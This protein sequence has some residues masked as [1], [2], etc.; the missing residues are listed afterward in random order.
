MTFKERSPD[1]LK[2]KIVCK[3]PF[4]NFS[5]LCVILQDSLAFL[6]VSLS[7]APV[8]TCPCVPPVTPGLWSDGQLHAQRLA[9]VVAGVVDGGVHNII[10]VVHQ[11]GHVLQGQAEHSSGVQAGAQRKTNT[12]GH[13]NGQSELL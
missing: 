12:V 13:G 7:V 1:S 4:S 5:N 11:A 6:R 3:G 8:L 2:L 9:L 10:N